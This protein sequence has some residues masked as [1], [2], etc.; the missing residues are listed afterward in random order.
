MPSRRIR[1]DFWHARELVSGPDRPFKSA[2]PD[3]ILPKKFNDRFDLTA[4]RLREGRRV[5]SRRIRSDSLARRR[6][7]EPAG[8]A[9]KPSAHWR[10]ASASEISLYI[11]LL[12]QEHAAA[13][14]ARPDQFSSEFG[15]NNLRF[16]L[17]LCHLIIISNFD[18]RTYCLSRACSSDG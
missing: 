15:V 1:S 4:D 6:V 9:V 14:S 13:K 11:V 12:F 16:D 3:H 17:N 10:K 2:R 8:P 7:G 18:I 5:A